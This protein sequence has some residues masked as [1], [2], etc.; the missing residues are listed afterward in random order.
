M[1]ETDDLRVSDDDRDRAIERLGYGTAEGRLTLEELT[2]RIESVHA[3]RTRG[4]L[5]RVTADL[6]ERASS[7]ATPARTGNRWLVSVFGDVA[8][9]GSWRAEGTMRPVSVFG[10]VELDLRQATLPA[11]QAEIRATSPFGNIEVLVP[12]GVEVDVSI[13]TLFGSKKIAVSE[14]LRTAST[15]VLR[16]RAFSLFGT[17]RIW[18]P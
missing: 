5:A 16:I 17:V 14:G 12:S 11:G 8:R 15:P 1:S 7:R 6:P 13:F 2:Q 9:S 3:A 10:D 18:T 4:E